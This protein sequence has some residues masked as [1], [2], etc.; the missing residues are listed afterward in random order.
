MKNMYV[1]MANALIEFSDRAEAHINLIG[2]FDSEEK[3]KKAVID[4]S[5]H[6]VV[7]EHKDVQAEMAEG[8]ADAC[9]IKMIQLN[10]MQSDLELDYEAY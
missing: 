3:A 8:I 6:H 7:D 1:V 10:Q 2:V 9:Q 4:Y 5:H